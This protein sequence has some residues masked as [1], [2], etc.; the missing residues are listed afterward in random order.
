MAQ[1]G[2]R[3]KRMVQGLLESAPLASGLE[4]GPP[5]DLGPF[6][7]PADFELEPELRAPVPRE[8]PGELRHR[9]M[10]RWRRSAAEWGT[11]GALL[12][13]AAQLPFVQHWALFVPLLEYLGWVGVALL[14]LA[15]GTQLWSS[16][17]K[18]RNQ[19]YFEYGTPRI[20]RVTRLWLQPDALHEG[21]PLNYRFA[22]T[23]EW[24]EDSEMLREKNVASVYFSASKKDRMAT[25]YRIGDYAT[26]LELNRDEVNLYGFLDLTP[27]FGVIDAE[28]APGGSIVRSALVAAGWFALAFGGCCAAYGVVRFEPIDT[29]TAGQNAVVFTVGPVLGLA[30]GLSAALYRL[31]NRSGMIHRRNALAATRGEAIELTMDD[32]EQRHRPSRR[33][34]LAFALA[35]MVIGMIVAAGSLILLNGLLDDSPATPERIDITDKKQIDHRWNGIPMTRSFT[36]EYRF[37]GKHEK[38]EFSSTPEAMAKFRNAAGMAFVHKGYFGLRWVEDIKP[39]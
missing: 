8:L 12:L 13:T 2:G 38:H 14:A 11:V 22:A 32:L 5:L 10:L 20:V 3:L 27:D 9:E 28:D 16:F 25:T 21:R 19:D 6:R 18:I 34:V 7:P 37:T 24:P 35:G 30:A 1:L 29:F 26:A 4:L 36:I 15:A 23:I 31:R 39:F 17:A 33:T